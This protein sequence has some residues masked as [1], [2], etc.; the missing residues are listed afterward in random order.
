MT[1]SAW[2]KDQ[3]VKL[4][5]ECVTG[6]PLAT[7]EMIIAH[8]AFESGYGTSTASKVNNY[9]N[10]SAG[11]SWKGATFDGPDLEYGRGSVK[12]IVQKWRVY[13]SAKECVEDYLALLGKERY[14]LAKCALMDG[15]AEQFIDYLGPDRAHQVPPVGGYF[16]L[17]TKVYLRSFLRV[18][19]EVQ[20]IMAPTADPEKRIK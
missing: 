17:A 1:V 18:L 8:A 11:S 20:A 15:N 12:K 13:D 10:V 9:F 6:Y 5:G 19:A 3:F 7:R 14:V 2:D 16:T 4:I